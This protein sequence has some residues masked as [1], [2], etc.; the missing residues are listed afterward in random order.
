MWKLDCKNS[1]NTLIL[2]KYL[3]VS[4][5]FIALAQSSHVMKFLHFLER[6]HGKME[7]KFTRPE[8]RIANCDNSRERNWEKQIF[9]F[10]LL[11]F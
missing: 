9:I 6:L 10:L 11:S 4:T 1:V 7:F 2:K 3:H 8:L 5:G